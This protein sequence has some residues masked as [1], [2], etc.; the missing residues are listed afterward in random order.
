MRPLIGAACLAMLPLA[1]WP[2]LERPFSVPK[3][4]WLVVATLAL[5]PL[6]SVRLPAS[7]CWLAGAWVLGFVIAGLAAPLPSLEAMVLGLAAPLFALALTRTGA[8]PLTLLTGQVV[9]ATTCA[10]VALMQWLGADPF[11]LAGWQPPIDGASVRMRV[12]GT[13]GNPNFVGVLM[14]MTLPLTLATLLS[15]TTVGRRRGAWAA[16]ALQAGALVATGSRGAVLGLTAAVAVHAALRWSRRVR[17]GLAAVAL[18]AG[19]AVGGTC[20]ASCRHAC[21]RLRWWGRVL[22]P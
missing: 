20:G 1:V 14:A 19:V 10:A 17:I 15:A 7:V 5:L 8:A 11:L 4:V 3:L 12:Y 6:P 2:G 13:L 21:G 22:V 18:F 16:L 9:G